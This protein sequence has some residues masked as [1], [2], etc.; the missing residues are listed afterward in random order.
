MIAH[1]R[2]PAARHGLCA[3]VGLAT[4]LAAAEG[5]AP[6]WSERDVDP[7]TAP[8]APEAIV[9]EGRTDILWVPTAYE[10]VLGDSRRYID[11]AA[12]D[13]ANDGTSKDTAW[14]HHPWDPAATG[15]AAEATGSHSYLFKGGVVYRG[16]LV[17]DESGTAEEPIRLLGDPGWGQGEAVITGSVAL[18]SWRQV[19]VEEASKLGF[20]AAA[21]G[22][23][24]AAEMPGEA[25][26]RAAWRL[27]ADGTRQRLT[28]ARY[29]N[30]QIEHPYDHFTQWLRID[31]DNFSFPWIR[32]RSDDLKGL[33][34]DSRKLTIWSDHP[35]KSGEF[36]IYGPFPSQMKGF[37]SATG[38]FQVRLE[39]PARHPRKGT[40]F[41]LENLPQFLDEAGEWWFD[42]ASRRLYLW[43][44][45]G[46]GTDALVVEAAA[47]EII[48]DI[49]AQRH[50]E[51]GGLTFTGGNVDDLRKAPDVEDY[52]ATPSTSSQCAIRLRGNCQD[53]DLHHLRVLDSAGTAIGNL[54]VDAADVVRGITIRD[55]EFERLDTTAVDLNRG[56]TYRRV[57]AHPKGSLTEIRILRNRFQNIGLR[58]N[59]SG[60]GNGVNLNG[61]EVCD[62][63]GNLIHTTGG[64]GINVIGGRP[65]GGWMG[66][67]APD[68]PLIR[69]QIR[70]NKVVDSL[71]YRTD[72]GGI[73]FWGIGPAYIYNNISANPVGFVAHRRV[74]HKNQA[75]YLDHGIKGYVFNNVGWSE[76]REDAYRGIVGENF[77]HEVRNRLNQGFHNTAYCF[78]SSLTHGSRYG[79]QQHYLAN[80]FVDCL[81]GVS[82]WTLGTAQE[83]AFAN[84]I[85]GGEFRDVYSRWKG[86]VFVTPDD[87]HAHVAP[88]DN[89]LSDSIGWA[90]N[91]PV[92]R[93]PEARDMRLADGSAAI[94][95][96]VRVFVPWSLSGEVGEWHF[97]KH[98]ADPQTV[99]GYDVNA[100]KI[101][102]GSHLHLGSPFPQN[103]LTAAGYTVDDYVAGPLEDWVDG[104][105]R[106]DGE[107]VLRLT[108]D[109]L[110]TDIVH[111]QDKKDDVVYPGSER[112]TVR[113]ER[114]NFLIEAVLKVEGDGV[115]AGKR[116][117]NAGYALM[118]DGGRP[119]LQ[120][121]GG[122]A[123]AVQTASVRI[124]DGA[125]HHVLVEVD[126]DDGRITIHVDGQD[127]SGDRSGDLPAAAISLDN[128]SDFVVG[129][130]LVGT[131]DYLRLARGTLADALTDIDELMS[132]QFNGPALHDFAGRAP[133][134]GVR[135]AGALEHESVSGRQPIRYTPP[136][137]EAVESKAAGDDDG[138]VVF[139]E[140][141]DRNL[142]VYDWGT[143]STPKT[144]KPG[145]YIDF[146]VVFGT[147]TVAKEQKL[148]VDVH[149]WRNG[150]R[151][152][153]AGQNYQKPT[154]V[155]GVTTPY[156]AGVKMPD[157]DKGFQE[158]SLIFY[159]SPDA[160]YS[161][162]TLGGSVN[163]GY[164]EAE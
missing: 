100:Q 119:A 118:V 115:L 12:G 2:H 67:N 109:A 155:P 59:S 47:H 149:G 9:T 10:P 98:P 125:W 7:W 45:E 162:K 72:F 23:L 152:P 15:L 19:P 44:P 87:Y 74:Y 157:A 106:L 86:E 102:H 62:I 114:G 137:V 145:E 127:V 25:T 116:D 95:R 153:G 31:E 136:A 24:H 85:F 163:V 5:P 4:C 69:I 93:D 151:V 56:L 53:I 159:L 66:G 34:L 3:L 36:S 108:N 82:H 130:G 18:E 81:S 60:S 33:D 61:I 46:V 43:L 128:D 142:K 75:I 70:H 148:V 80:V 30:W 64:Q 126:R 94:D 27:A 101:F 68:S 49:H 77:L 103:H 111:K 99:L 17:A 51:I 129:D 40:P 20:P 50:I 78:R 124:D 134:G 138:G 35:N 73:E 48:L 161:N 141:P 91:D 123:K 164:P 113:F 133:T 84:N 121:L 6:A 131:L 112:E 37:D 135:D 28:L 11:F 71:L 42:N 1:L 104:A 39:H 41:Y 107:R 14:K 96:G 150:K 105:V 32:L 16:T 90:T 156:T 143:V 13:D 38:D 97:R 160:N 54:I 117:A 110:F 122:G 120:I 132:F 139:K 92:L 22:Q 79:D 146:Q 26:P 144:M 158:V 29:P 147:E 76:R 8:V 83:I 154:V 89:H 52:T 21:H 57:E 58:S 55:S 65:G 88:L 140:G 63:A